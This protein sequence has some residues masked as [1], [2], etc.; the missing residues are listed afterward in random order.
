MSKE[1]INLSKLI[2]LIKPEI[3]DGQLYLPKLCRDFLKVFVILIFDTKAKQPDKS[4]DWC[5]QKC[6]ND[7]VRD[8]NRG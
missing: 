2:K 7:L 5:A 6:I 8:R 1:P 4:L 3:I